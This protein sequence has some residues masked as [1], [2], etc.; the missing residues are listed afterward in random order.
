MLEHKFHI[1]V[2]GL[3]YT[4]DTPVKVAHLGISSVVSIIQD[5][6]L[7]QMREYY[8]NEHNLPYTHIPKSDVNHRAKRITAYLNL[9]NFLVDQQTEDLKNQ[10]FDQE[11]QIDRYFRLLPD[12]AALKQDYLKMTL[13]SGEERVKSQE[14]LRQAITAGSIDVNIMTKIDNINY[15]KD[16]EALPQEYSDALAALRGFAES[17]LR[18]GVVLSAGLNPRLVAYMENFEDFYPDSEGSLRK[19]II[20]KVSDFRSAQIQGKFFAKRG[21][22]ISEF[23]VESGLNC[24][25]HAFPT[26]GHLLG[27]ILEEFKQHKT[28]LTAELRELCNQSLEKAGKHLIPDD[29]GI[30]VSAQG[31]VGT[32]AEHGF[33]LSYYELDTIGWGSPFLLVPEATNVDE[34]T[35]QAITVAK[36]EDYFLSEASPL[37]VPFNNFKLSSGERQRNERIAKHRPGSPCPQKHLSFNTEFTKMPICTSSRQYQDLKIKELDKLALDQESYQKRFE[38]ITAKDCL[39]DGL[40]ATPLLNHKLPMKNHQEAV[41]IC[42]G[43]NLAYFSKVRTLDEMVGHIYGRI[44]ILNQT[45]RPHVF[46]N[47]LGMYI[48]YLM[49]EVEKSIHEFSTGQSKYFNSFKQ[50]LLDG[51]DYYKRLIPKMNLEPEELKSNMKMEFEQMRQKLL[52]FCLPSNEMNMLKA[53]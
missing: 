22:W 1:P 41:T 30:M 4:V 38:E 3:G 35:M 31:G 32:A 25:G 24:G 14:K 53:I 49:S 17:D 39:C 37:G 18:A 7:E 44:H 8:C 29:L 36:K 40:S 21:L 15:T 12:D 33:L 26:D 23:R 16:G 19:T 52:N 42:P 27:P 43:P 6:L 46:I 48:D 5:S 2:M 50:N 45:Y 10:A 13:L 28:R 9:L 34:E 11:N 51:I 47:E 20:L